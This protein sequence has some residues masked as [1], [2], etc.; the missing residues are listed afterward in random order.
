VTREAAALE[1]QRLAGGLAPDDACCQRL[2]ER[3]AA[4]DDSE[5]LRAVLM[6]RGARALLDELAP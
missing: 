1:L 2:L 6:E 5:V 4:S 3:I